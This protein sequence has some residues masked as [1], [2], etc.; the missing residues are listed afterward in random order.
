MVEFALS[1]PMFLLLLLAVFDLARMS[2]TYV[3]LIN[4]AREAA[5]V[6]AFSTGVTDPVVN[7]FNNQL[8][9]LG[10][11]NPTDTIVITIADGVCAG[12]MLTN[13]GSTLAA[14]CLGNQAGANAGFYRVATCTPGLP[15]SL[16]NCTGN[17][18]VAGTPPTLFQRNNFGGGYVDLSVTSNFTLSPL[19]DAML[20]T[21]QRTT[22]APLTFV[23]STS[24]RAY[25]E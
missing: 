13:P 12:R 15:L 25:I 23:L 16:S 18:I 7:A 10:A 1:L 5:R 21:V 2:F 4:A 24:T 20:G 3:M 14:Q 6:A 8:I 9:Y 19:F 22:G 17:G 11:P